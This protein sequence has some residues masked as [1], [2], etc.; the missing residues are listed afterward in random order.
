ME[1]QHLQKV[2]IVEDDG[3][4]RKV[5]R[6]ILE[7]IGFQEIEEAESGEDALK[8]MQDQAVKLVLV[9]WH[10]S[11]LSG[12]DLLKTIKGAGH[13]THVKI[14]MVTNNN[15]ETNILEA[16]Q[17]GVDGYIMKPFSKTNIQQKIEAVLTNQLF[18]PTTPGCPVEA[19]SPQTEQPAATVTS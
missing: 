13:L 5:L 1:Y 12:L 10:V 14:F 4:S 8:K 3:T 19:E 18:E 9:D 2:L 17:A 15:R 16:V 11:G 7:D 6:T